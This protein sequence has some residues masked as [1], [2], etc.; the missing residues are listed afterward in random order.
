MER[1]FQ[2]VAL[3][4]T[5]TGFYLVRYGNVLASRGSVVPTL[6]AQAAAGVPITLTDPRMTRFW[7]TLDDAVDLVLRAFSV[8]EGE[9]LIPACRAASM[10]SL[11]EAIAPG[12]PV[13]VIGG[14]GGEKQH[15]ALLN[16]VEAPWARPVPGGWA[17][18]SLA[19]PVRGV[20]P[21]PFDYTSDTAPAVPVE[22]LRQTVLSMTAGQPV[23]LL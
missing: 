23:R 1:L 14:R 10:E 21:E 13:R 6:Q 11:A 17:L 16:G 8:D 5:G 12:R 15:E 9:V 4:G 19:L 22:E 18:A 2:S 20:L 3:S 7:L